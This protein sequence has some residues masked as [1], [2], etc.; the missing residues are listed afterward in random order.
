M[1]RNIYWA[2]IVSARHLWKWILANSALS[3]YLDW[4][5]AATRFIV[6]IMKIDNRPWSCRWSTA[7]TYRR[8]SSTELWRI[9]G[10]V[11]WIW[12]SELR[13][14]DREFWKFYRVEVPIHDSHNDG[15]LEFKKMFIS[16]KCMKKEL[17]V[18]KLFPNNSR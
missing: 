1:T 11:K 2:I 12:K 15:V 10:I 3:H 5:R 8:S 16:G 4:A 14:F 9:L 17:Y 6:I 7:W 13:N 18:N